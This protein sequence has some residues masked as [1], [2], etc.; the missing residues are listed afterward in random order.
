VFAFSGDSKNV[1]VIDAVTTRTLTVLPLGGGPEFAH[2]DGEGFLFVNLEDKNQ[3][4]KIDAKKM[5]VVERWT[6]P[7]GSA[8]SSLGIDPENH[9]L[10]IGCRNQTLV[11]LDSKS[12]KQLVT[13]PIGKWV[14]TAVYDRVGRRIFVS[15]GDGTLTVIHQDSADTYTVEEVFHTKLGS[16]TM[17][18]D[19]STATIYV[20]SATLKPIPP[21][22]PEHPTPHRQPIDGT[23][24]ILVW[25]QTATK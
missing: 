23:F 22:T 6:L 19:S 14:D 9:R 5:A 17:A 10:F 20:P 18:F 24:K 2:V 3:V 12:G 4:L 21:P 1:T 25:N 7:V 8:P 15:C 13:L 16:A 11:V